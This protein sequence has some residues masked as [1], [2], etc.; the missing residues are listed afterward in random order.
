MRI[1]LNPIGT[2]VNIFHN[3]VVQPWNKSY[4]QQKLFTLSLEMNLQGHEGGGSDS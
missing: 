1:I 2:I 4:I 3:T